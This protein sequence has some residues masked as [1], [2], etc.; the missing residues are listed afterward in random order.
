[1]VCNNVKKV[2]TVLLVILVA[3]LLVAV[4]KIVI[5]SIIKSTSMSADGFHSLSDG[6]SNIVGLVGIWYASKPVDTD[7]P[8][9]HSKFETLSGLFIGGMLA[10]VGINVIIEAFKRF[11]HP[12]IPNIT[13]ESI[14]T[15]VVTL[16]IN[17]FVSTYEFKEG[18][19]L[20]SQILISDSLHT[21]SDIYVSLGV[22]VTL[23]CISLGLPAIIDPVA[24]VIVALFIFHASYEIFMENS[25]VLLDKAAV[26]SEKVREIVLK[27]PEVKDIHQIRSRGRVDEMFID[28]HVMAEPSMSIAASHVLI[29]SIEGKMRE[30]LSENTQ[31]IVHLEPYYSHKK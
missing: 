21:R 31:V 27:F 11:F 16:G 17:I 30:E 2:R 5:G 9:G 29:H 26:D 14:I 1:M 24:S 22:L 6:S 15:L 7:H 23:L 13:I 8:Y 4:L 25:G 12:V 3:N 19:K 20:N 10:V 18:K 28:L